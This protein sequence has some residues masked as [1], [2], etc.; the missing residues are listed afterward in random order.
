MT[1][2]DLNRAVQNPELPV[3]DVMI[4]R[5]II[6]AIRRGDSKRV[7]FLLNRTIGKVKEDIEITNPD[8][9]LQKSTVVMLPSNGREKKN[10]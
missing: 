5:V 9:S 8:G 7:E 10:E 2:E 3:L 1:V 6:E 4:I